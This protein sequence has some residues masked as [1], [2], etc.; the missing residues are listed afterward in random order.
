MDEWA[1]EQASRI[2]EAGLLLHPSNH[3]SIPG[4]RSEADASRRRERQCVANGAETGLTG[5]RERVTRLRIVLSPKRSPARW[6]NRHHAA[7]GTRAL[8]RPRRDRRSGRWRRADG[9]SR[10]APSPGAPVAAGDGRV[11]RRPHPPRGQGAHLRAR[12]HERVA[13]QPSRRRQV[14]SPG[15]AHREMGRRSH[16]R[17][18]SRGPLARRHRVRLPRG[19]ERQG[20]RRALRRLVLRRQRRCRQ[21][22]RP[23]EPD[24]D[25]FVVAEAGV[26]VGIPAGGERTLPGASRVGLWHDPLRFE[27]L[28]TGED[29]KGESGL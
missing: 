17:H 18:G 25:W 5:S 19:I 10:R 13:G 23:L 16:P 4:L 9:P 1:Q 3:P 15:Q 14:A 2:G 7:Y 27:D 11:G 26:E 22:G 29:K 12:P 6:R 24:S 28:R 21:H 20:H 8:A